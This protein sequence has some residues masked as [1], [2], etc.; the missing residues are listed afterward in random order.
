MSSDFRESFEGEPSGFADPRAQQDLVTKRRGS[1]VVDLVPQN[2]PADVVL[3]FR[4]GNRL[5][6]R[7]GNILDPPEVNGVVHVILLVYVVRED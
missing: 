1:F 3:C 5:P 6:M 7:S 2:D 4:A